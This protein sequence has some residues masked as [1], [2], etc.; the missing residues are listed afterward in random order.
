MDKVGG[1]DL[2]LVRGWIICM[3]ISTKARRMKSR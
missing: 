3:K 1:I 2:S